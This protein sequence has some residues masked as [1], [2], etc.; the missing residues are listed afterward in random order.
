LEGL[1]TKTIDD[2]KSLSLELDKLVNL[3]LQQKREINK[4]REDLSLANHEISLLRTN[5]ENLKNQ[6]DEIFK[7]FQTELAKVSNLQVENKKL[8]KLLKNTDEKLST[9]EIDSRRGEDN[10]SKLKMEFKGVLEENNK[11]RE[12]IK[13]LESQLNFLNVK[14]N[15]EI[16][17]VEST[18]NEFAVE[19]RKVKDENSSLKTQEGNL[20]KDI[21]I[22]KEEK[23]K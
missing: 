19:I 23:T 21:E 10:T 3:K 5:N 4:I 22:F 20:I 18:I 11:Q 17:K 7:N 9:R 2:K 13:K 12:Y 6:N 8:L 1:L 16:T 15:D 14:Q